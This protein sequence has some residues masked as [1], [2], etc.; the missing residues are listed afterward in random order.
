MNT[1]FILLA[2]LWSH[3]GPGLLLAFALPVFL[4]LGGVILLQGTKRVR[5]RMRGAQEGA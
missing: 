5:D 1:A 2:D 4:I 3:V